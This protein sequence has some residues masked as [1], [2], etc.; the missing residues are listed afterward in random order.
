MVIY[1]YFDTRRY[2][3][4]RPGWRVLVP[5]SMMLMVGVAG[6]LSLP[7]W[8]YIVLALTALGC[9]LWSLPARTRQLIKQLRQL[10]GGHIIK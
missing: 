7:T 8:V 10:A 6:N 4:L 1:R 2:F 5:V 3:A 9:T